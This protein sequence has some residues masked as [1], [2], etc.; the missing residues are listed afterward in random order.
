MSS[1][2]FHES[3]EGVKHSQVM[4]PTTTTL[5]VSFTCA[6]FAMTMSSIGSF[7]TYFYLLCGGLVSSTANF[8]HAALLT[9]CRLLGFSLALLLLRCALVLCIPA[10]IPI[11]YLFPLG[12]VLGFSGGSL[13][14]GSLCVLDPVVHFGV[15]LLG[16][17]YLLVKSY[18]GM[19]KPPALAT[20][21]TF[22]DAV[23]QVQSIPAPPSPF[24]Q[25]PVPLRLPP[26]LLMQ[27][28]MIPARPS[29][30]AIVSPPLY[31]APVQPPR[32]RPAALPV[33]LVVRCVLPFLDAYHVL[34]TTKLFYTYRTFSKTILA[35][36]HAYITTLQQ[37]FVPDP[38]RRTV[39]TS[40]GGIVYPDLESVMR[41]S[42]LRQLPATSKYSPSPPTGVVYRDIDSIVCTFC[43]H[44]R[45]DEQ[46]CHRK[47]KMMKKIAQR[48]PLGASADNQWGWGYC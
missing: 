36:H 40:V 48:P 39:R 16:S 22:S 35:W 20:L 4:V 13:L 5:L 23:V 21:V 9:A 12:L 15:L 33:V 24:L 18:C 29:N 27:C 25:V 44:R 19:E 46:N 34:Y 6:A 43:G 47:E 45:H 11:G 31:S 7:A 3:S 30:L 38:V 42:S 26:R 41:S 1:V 8:I 28:P 37:G 17:F 32:P 2:S 10:S 14:S